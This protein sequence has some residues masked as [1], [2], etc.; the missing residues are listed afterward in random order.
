MELRLRHFVVGYLRRSFDSPSRLGASGYI[1]EQCPRTRP[2]MEASHQ[3]CHDWSTNVRFVWKCLSSHVMAIADA[4]Q[5]ILLDWRTDFR[6]NISIATN[7]PTRIWAL[8]PRRWRT[9][10]PIHDLLVYWHNRRVDN[11]W[12]AQSATYVHHTHRFMPSN[13]R[14][15]TVEYTT[16][17]FRS[18]TTDIWLSNNCW[19]WLWHECPSL[20]RRDPFCCGTA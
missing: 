20:L 1:S 14:L 11:S 2:S 5:R 4:I 9:G 17:H 8:R 16:S 12:Q 13:N 10:H 18:S 6:C 7:L 19:P 15:C 3:S